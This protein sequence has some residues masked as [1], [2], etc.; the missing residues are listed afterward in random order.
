MDERTKPLL[1]FFPGGPGLSGSCLGD[2]SA[3]T[4]FQSIVMNPS[5]TAPLDFASVVTGMESQLAQTQ[6]PLILVG[7]SFGGLYATEL[8]IRGKLN[9]IAWVGLATSV[10]AEGFSGVRDRYLAQESVAMAT[11]RETFYA[12]PFDEEFRDWLVALA[13]V[14][15]APETRDQG[16]SLLRQDKLS[17]KAYG[18][19][20]ESLS[21]HSI[22]TTGAQMLK[23]FTG[24][25]LS[26]AGSN[27]LFFPPELIQEEAKL[28]GAHSLTVEGSHHFLTVDRPAEVARLLNQ[29]FI[30]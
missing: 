5:Q 9:I 23:G 6:R 2:L 19:I 4:A 22:L 10:T 12:N 27:D 26:L 8:L 29:A 21:H 3:F 7:H 28:V 17:A 18:E 11:A 25:K 13:P 30:S 20:S 15:F 24:K 1:C 14:Y 16:I